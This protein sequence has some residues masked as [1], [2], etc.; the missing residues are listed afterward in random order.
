MIPQVL[1]KFLHV[2]SSIMCITASSS[3]KIIVGTAHI[4]KEKEQK[5][6][7]PAHTEEGRDNGKNKDIV[8]NSVM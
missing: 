6:V 5:S 7:G 4:E 3:S 2:K 1:M 8:M